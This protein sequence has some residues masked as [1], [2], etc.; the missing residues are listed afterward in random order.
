M[1]TKRLVI[2]HANCIDGFTAAWA[3]WRKFGNEDT[4]YLAASYG[5]APPDVIGRDVYIVDF[6]YPRDVM[7]SLYERAN[8]LLVLDHHVTAQKALEG[9]SCAIFD[10]NRSGAGLAWDVLNPEA[11]RP[12]LVDYVED[13]DLWRFARRHSKAV[14][15][16]ISACRRDSF[17][18][19]DALWD[20]GPGRAAENGAAV[21]A[22]VDRYVSEMAA[23]ARTIDFAGHRVPIVNAPYI[24]I[25]ELVGHLAESAPFAVGWFQ[26][27]DG[28][29]AC[30]LRSRGPDG[31]DVSEI[32]KRFGGGGHRNSAGFVLAERLSEVGDPDATVRP[33]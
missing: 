29:Y 1:N 10:M 8:S 19:W 3:A 28:L 25:S 30:S 13:R 6:S 31:V 16:W 22:F 15:A 2:Y 17:R 5:D 21:L 14:N 18:D 24:N 32:A 7:L 23:Q 11:P 4:E 9:L 26:R 12:W 33:E 20:L 27:G